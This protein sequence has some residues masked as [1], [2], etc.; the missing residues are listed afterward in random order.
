MKLLVDDYVY[1]TVE[2]PPSYLL[3]VRVLRIMNSNIFVAE[4][5]P[6]HGFSCEM[7]RVVRKT[8]KDAPR[9]VKGEV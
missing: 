1:V 6:G 2:R 9:W 5:V 7:S 3:R 8:Y 4:T